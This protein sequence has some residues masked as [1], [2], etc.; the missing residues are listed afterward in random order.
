MNAVFVIG[1]LTKNVE[2]KF[3]LEKNK[4]AK[5]IINLKLADKT[6]IKVADY[7]EIADFCVRNLKA[8][9]RV[10]IYGEIKENNVEIKD[11]EK[12]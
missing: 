7:N 12:I 6:E 10:I 5:V 1:N 11:V 2:Y 8:K 4:T 9:D 3:M